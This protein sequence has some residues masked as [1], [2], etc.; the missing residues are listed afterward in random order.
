MKT[1]INEYS[2]DNIKWFKEHEGFD[3]FKCDIKYQDNIIGSFSENYM[4]GP[5]EYYFKGNFNDELEK[6]RDAA[7][8]FFEKYSKDKDLIANKFGT[9][10]DFFIRFLRNLEE[11]STNAIEGEEIYISTSYPF[12][13]EIEKNKSL[14]NPKLYIDTD[15]NKLIIPV[16]MFNIN[17]DTMEKDEEYGFEG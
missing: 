10:E 13:Y 14:N 12:N 17:I 3:A 16:I 9:N 11:A 8:S 2:V 1:T 7:N 4:N 6:L 15:E 5:D